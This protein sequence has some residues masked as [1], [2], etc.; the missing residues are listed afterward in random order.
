MTGVMQLVI[1]LGTVRDWG[2]ARCGGV[3]SGKSFIS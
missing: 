2:T 1:W 3:V